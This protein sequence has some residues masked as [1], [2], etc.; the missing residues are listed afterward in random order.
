MPSSVTRGGRGGSEG[1]ARPR[2]S[3]N[4]SA[5][6]AE[7][8]R[9]AAD[10]ANASS[11]TGPVSGRPRRKS[12]RSRP[13]DPLWAKMLILGGAL[14][15]MLSGGVLVGGKVLIS[16]ATDAIDTESMLGDAAVN[17]DGDTA[18]IEG[19]INILML[20]L[21]ERED[22]GEP[23]RADSIIIL[24]V[25]STH[26]QAYLISVPRDLYVTIP[27]VDGLHETSEKA[28]INAAYA[29]GSD[30]GGRS[31]G[32]E[33]LAA[34]LKNV[35]GISFN[36]AGIVNF[37]GFQ[38]VVESLGGV[39]M[40]LDQ[41]TDSAHIGRDDAGNLVSIYDH[42]DATP[43]H[44]DVGCRDL[45]AWEALDYVRQRKE[46]PNTDYDRA[47][48]QQ[49]FIKAVLKEAKDQGITSSPTKALALMEAA[50]EA[51][52]V[53][54]GGIDLATWAITLRG[55]TD[56]ELVMLK[57]NAGTFVPETLSDGTQVELLSDDSKLM[58][59]ALKNDALAEFVMTHPDFIASD[60]ISTS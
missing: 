43:V 20:G 25:P 38:D 59:E 1:R 34:T 36:A 57:T 11:R 58:M 17:A 31:G 33:V 28:K 41:E 44:Y 45:E 21:D 27:V 12:G 39:Y 14:L 50:G 32:V 53:D 8:A 35:T 42:P 15:M 9:P 3:S 2:P 52:T 47:R 54:T 48:H 30:T 22:T 29:Y 56:N 6:M 18:S 46:F 7:R 19:A 16:S 40:C 51:L 60:T 13:K 49:Q 37:G 23:V 4:H 5:P 26:D 10:R 55:V 24:H